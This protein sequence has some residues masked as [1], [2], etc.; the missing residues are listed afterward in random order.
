MS[1]YRLYPV[2]PVQR[3]ISTTLS[4]DSLD[5]FRLPHDFFFDQ[6]TLYPCIYILRRHLKNRVL[7][8]HDRLLTATLALIHLQGKC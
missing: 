6:I 2:Y 8:N 4:R 7:K 5:S 3:A 1:P